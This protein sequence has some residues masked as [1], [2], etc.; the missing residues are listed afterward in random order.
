MTEHLLSEAILFWGFVAREHQPPHHAFGWKENVWE[1]ELARR[2]GIEP[3]E[4][5]VSKK[6]HDEWDDWRTLVHHAVADWAC[7][8]SWY[9]TETDK[10]YFV[11]LT[12]SLHIADGATA[13]R[14]DDT[15]PIPHDAWRIKLDAFCHLLHI[16]R[17]PDVPVG[18][19]LVARDRAFIELSDE[20][21]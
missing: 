11:A 10:R 15:M 9:G 8:F 18:W 16:P 5:V 20:P 13:L 4:P 1:Y 2:L 14:F 3:P 19:R 12:Q 6:R 17:D 21:D 7:T